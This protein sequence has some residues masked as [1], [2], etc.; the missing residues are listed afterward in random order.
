MDFFEAIG[1]RR[2]IRAYEQKPVED[3]KLAR[4]LEAVRLAPTA[5]NKQPFRIVVVQTAGREAELKRVYDKDWFLS[6]PL[7]LLACSVPGSAWTRGDGKN[8]GDVD[9]TIAMDHLILA[10]TALGLGSC[11]VANFDAKSAKEIFHLD[12]G[13]EPVAMTPLG[14]AKEAPTPRPRKSLADIVVRR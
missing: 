10:A 8:Y 3:E 6:A 11:W 4:I 9:A 12:E 2:S 7:I 5:C 14:Y 1:S 13:W